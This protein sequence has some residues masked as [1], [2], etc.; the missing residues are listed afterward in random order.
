MIRWIVLQTHK[1][2]HFDNLLQH[3]LDRDISSY[4]RSPPQ[5]SCLLPHHTLSRRARNIHL[6]QIHNYKSFKCQRCGFPCILKREWKNS[7]LLEHKN[8]LIR[9]PGISLCR[10]R[11]NSHQSGIDGNE[12]DVTGITLGSEDT[13]SHCSPTSGSSYVPSSSGSSSTS[14]MSGHTESTCPP[15]RVTFFRRKNY[16][17]DSSDED[18]FIKKIFKIPKKQAS[19][20]S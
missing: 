3:P 4:G 2:F 13:V 8:G 9:K 19:H 17:S 11:H 1:S 15:S 12:S 20:I 6:V 16:S 10:L 18:F 14:N 5:P 7:C